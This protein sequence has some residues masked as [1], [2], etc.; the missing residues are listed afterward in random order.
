MLITLHAILHTEINILP[1]IP[2]QKITLVHLRLSQ[3]KCPAKFVFT[4]RVIL[5]RGQ[6]GA[7]GSKGQG[8][9]ATAAG[10]GSDGSSSTQP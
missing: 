9:R 5:S 6:S 1:E 2:G 8:S 7:K 4:A 10:E 3:A